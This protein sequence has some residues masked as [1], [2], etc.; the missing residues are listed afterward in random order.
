VAE[1]LTFRE[2]LRIDV[3]RRVW[4][5]QVISLF[6]DFVALFA[7]ISVVTYRMHGT[8]SQVTGI[9]I[10]YMLPVGV[11]GLLSGVFVDRWPLK[12]TL[13]VSDLLRA[14]LVALLIFATTLWQYYAVLVGISCVSSFF[15]PAQS[16]TI[17]SHVPR[18]GLLNANSLMQLAFMGMRV[19]GPATATALVVAVGAALCY[20]LDVISFLASAALIASVAI[21]RGFEPPTTGGGSGPLHSLWIDMQQGIRFIAG[22]PSVSFVV[23]AM[24]AGMFTVGCFGPLIAI[25]VRDSLHATELMYGIVSAMVGVG[26]IIGTVNIRR[27]AR[28][29]SNEK[30]VLFGLGGIGIGAFILGTLPYVSAS[31]VA[32]LSIGVTFAAIIVPAQ[33]LLQQE[34]PGAMMG[35]VS[36]STGSVVL[37]AQVLGLVLSGWLADLVGIRAV[38][39]GCAAL[40]ATLAV[41]GRLLLR[42]PR[43]TDAPAVP[44]AE[45]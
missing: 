34:T 2:V 7:V 9:Q 14:G 36:A 15:G 19:I 25:Y 39:L 6:G 44:L 22:H 37:T 27:A 20:V 28:F 21:R 35:R 45:V 1:S 33:T 30:L 4:Y 43:G 8:P 24:A 13:I 23:A 3:M 42:V 29:A 32:T 18:E 16:V 17:R 10:A 26:L 38:F 41:A 12:P 5:A 31:V 40:A 11:L